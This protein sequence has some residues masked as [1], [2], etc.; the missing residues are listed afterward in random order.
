[1]RLQSSA[2]WIVLLTVCMLCGC[3]A[4]ERK[5]DTPT[6]YLGVSP[7]LETMARGLV[8]AYR[9]AS[10]QEPTF[11]ITVSS[12]QELR[13]D[14]DQARVSAVLE[15]DPPALDDWAAA[16]G[17]TGIVFV[18]NPQNTVDNLSRD[19]AR[20]IFLGLTDD[21]GDVGGS[22]GDIHCLAYAPDQEMADLFQGV[23]L[24]SDRTAN[25]FQA[26]PAPYA[27]RD[28]VGKDKNSIGFLLGFDISREIRPL[29]ID[30]TTAEYPNLL[31]SKYPFRVPVYLISKKNGPADI[32]QFAGWTQSVAGQSVFLSLQPWE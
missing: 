7:S 23:V 29:T 19:Q 28:A 15:W 2:K 20:D 18:V 6:L 9:L 16:L 12:S 24:N 27:M 32:S 21:W 4:A 30:H 11:Q 17:W 31:S 3:Q 25:G 26:V 1:M 8:E 5:V 14:L 10:P 22:S 13:S